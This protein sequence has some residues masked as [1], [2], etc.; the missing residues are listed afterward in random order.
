MKKK[1]TTPEDWAE[2]VEEDVKDWVKNT[3]KD[4]PPVPPPE[5]GYP[6]EL[7]FG[8][9]PENDEETENWEN[10]WY[11][12]GEE[13]SLSLDDIPLVMKLP[14]DVLCFENCQHLELDEHTGQWREAGPVVFRRW[15]SPAAAID[16]TRSD[17]G[18]HYSLTVEFSTKH[19]VWSPQRLNFGSDQKQ[20]IRAAE[21][22]VAKIAQWP[23]L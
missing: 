10:Q 21:K 14:D 13:P 2:I 17:D 6:G 8:K 9:E 22:L 16:L 12:P 3:P 4:A 7:K 20:A 1:E 18:S 5:L 19:F 15:I 23:L 11:G